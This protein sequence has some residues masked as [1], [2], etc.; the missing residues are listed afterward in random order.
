MS[1]AGCGGSDMPAPGATLYTVRDLMEQ[2]PKGVLQQVADIG[3]VNIEATNYEDGKF[4]GMAPQEFKSYLGEIGLQPLS[5]HQGGV[6]MENADQ[7]IADT[8]AAGF[9]YFVIPVPPMGRFTFDP[10]TRTLGMTGTVQE[11]TDIVN[12]LAQKCKAA[13]L[14]LLYHN[15]D[16]EFKPNEQGIIP[17]DYMLEN[18]DPDLVNFQMDLY[19]VT[20]AGADP[21]DYFEKYPDRF[22]IWHVKDMDS[23]GRFAPVG[24]GTIDFKRIVA[25]KEQSGMEY[26]IVEQD[27]TFDGMQP[28]EAIRTSYENLDEIGLR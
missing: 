9:R 2:D 7:M 28:L 25:K 22:K 12:T 21:L 11:L 3:Y 4:Y 10:E 23:Q 19:W 8:K 1:L 14:E 18:T 13:G 24:T 16:F 5:V 26:Y 15:H 20:R 6:T 27:M 17:I